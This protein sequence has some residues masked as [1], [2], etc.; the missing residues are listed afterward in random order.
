MDTRIAHDYTRR[1]R[2]D[3]GTG[4]FAYD[5][6]ANGTRRLTMASR[7]PDDIVLSVK[8]IPDCVPKASRESGIYYRL[9]FI[10]LPLFNIFGPI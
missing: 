8:C 9:R 10:F 4:S 6:V 2:E 7:W 3:R 5:V 1:T